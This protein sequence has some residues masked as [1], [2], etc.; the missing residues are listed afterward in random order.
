M[1]RE[2]VIRPRNWLYE[3]LVCAELA[4]IVAIWQMVFRSWLRTFM[5]GGTTYLILAW[6]L[7]LTLQRH[8]RKGMKLLRQKQ[9]EEAAAAFQNS[10][11]FFTKH[12]WID[13]CR[14]ITMFSSNAIPFG[15]MAVNNLGI[16]YLHMGED[17]KALEAFTKLAEISG[18]YPNITTIIAE[19][20]KHIDDTARL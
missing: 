18:N 17:A 12:P 3:L 4:F 14:F 9:Y 13:K 2:K 15:Q 11:S 1:E 20:Q 19:I 5:F 10:F 7:R 6:T 8:H 16:C